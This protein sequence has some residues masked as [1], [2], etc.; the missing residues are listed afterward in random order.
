[1]RSIVGLWV[2]VMGCPF[3]YAGE[4]DDAI[5]E[6]AATVGADP[7]EWE[8]P[9]PLCIGLDY[10][11]V[12]DYIFRGINYSE[13][14]G[15]GRER[16][17][18]QVT[19]WAEVDTGCAGTVGGYL[20]FEFY[21]GLRHILEDPP[22][23]LYEV[24]YALYWR[25]AFEPIGTTVELGFAMYDYP[26]ISG[27]AGQTCEA[28]LKLTFDDSGLFGTEEPVLNPMLGYWRDVNDIEGGWLELSIRHPFALA[29]FTVT[30]SLALGVDHEYLGKALGTGNRATQ[31]G[32]LTVGL[33]VAYD[34]GGALGLPAWSGGVTLAGFMFRSIALEEDLL[35]DEF[36][37]GLKVSW[38]W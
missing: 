18:H 36:W 9:I 5:S 1:M 14:S 13:Y 8:K 34:L 37:G 19:A 31:F 35:N 24:D 21:D 23:R 28:W 38:S 22:N 7:E 12:S 33:E 20:W 2:L 11:L 26:H 6:A 30:Q 17:N 29:V 15:E 10:V 25:H 27:S 32:N 3:V 4:A 16:L